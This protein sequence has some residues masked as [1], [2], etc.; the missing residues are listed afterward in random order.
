M[1]RKPQSDETVTLPPSDGAGDLAELAELDAAA[2]FSGDPPPPPAA[3]PVERRRATVQGY[4]DM[5]GHWIDLAHRDIAHP[6]EL[7]FFVPAVAAGHVKQGAKIRVLVSDPLA[8]EV[9]AKVLPYT[10]DDEFLR[11][12]ASV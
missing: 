3:E 11:E 2:D 8:P 1:S 5:Q 7:A 10:G 4:Y 6:A 12:L 9:P